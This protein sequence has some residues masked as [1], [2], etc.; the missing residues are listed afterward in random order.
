MSPT[1]S[2]APLAESAEIEVT[3]FPLDG[4]GGLPL[5][6]ARSWL[7]EDELER[8]GRFRFERHRDR[9]LRGRGMLRALL[10]ARLGRTPEEL[11]FTTGAKGKPALAG[12]GPGF[13]LS[14][15]EGRAVLA[16]GDLPDL[17]VD[18]EGY[19][20]RVDLDGLARRCFRPSEI[21][22]M[23]SFPPERRH[24]A[25]FR[26]WTAKEARMKATGEG[27][28]LEPQRIE[29]R[30]ADGFPQGIAEPAEPAAHLASVV[31]PGGECACCVV[32]LEPFRVRLAE[33]PAFDA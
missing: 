17:G 11:A 26:I 18:I 13:N 3:P 12:A 7:S 10:A 16:V 33:P 8:A 20:R 28:S 27:F 32:A 30:F 22:W 31:L 14:H 23:A 9:Y 15:S 29:L 25:F 19:D 24:L 4:E 2:V 5:A 1:P 6:L 21:A